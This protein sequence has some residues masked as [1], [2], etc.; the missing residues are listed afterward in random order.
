MILSYEEVALGFTR[1]ELTLREVREFV[2]ATADYDDAEIVVLTDGFANQ[3]TLTVR[4][5]QQRP[6]KPGDIQ[7]NP[8]PIRRGTD[9]PCR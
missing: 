8:A 9:G 4:Q 1:G 2:R 6:I 7:P 3:S 5:L